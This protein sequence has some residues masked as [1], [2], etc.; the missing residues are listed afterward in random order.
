MNGRR[1]TGR[2]DATRAPGSPEAWDAR[3]EEWLT[4]AEEPGTIPDAEVGETRVVDVQPGEVR[5]VDVQLGE[6]RVADARPEA[7]SAADARHGWDAESR[8]VAGAASH[9]GAHA[10]AGAGAGVGAAVAPVSGRKPSAHVGEAAS[11]VRGDSAYGSESVGSDRV[12]SAYARGGAA[13]DRKPSARRGAVD[14]VKALMHRHR[15]LCERAVD[16]LEIAA[17]LEAH[18][19]T[20]RTATRFRHR[21]VFSLAEEMYARVPRAGDPAPQSEAPDTPGVRADWALLTLLPGA[22]CAAT[23]TGLRLTEGRPRLAVA[24]VGVFAISMG[25]RAAVRRGPLRA[26]RAWHPTTSTRAWTC[27]LLA[28]ALLGDGLLAAGIE[29]GPTGP[30]TGGSDSPWPIALASLLALTLAVVPAAWC[31]HLF[32][33]RARRRLATSRGLEE[34]ASSVRPLLLGVFGLFLCALSG[35]L[36]GSGAWLGEPPAYAAAGA[37]GALLL[38]A[39]LLT[40]HGFTHAPAVIL[41]AAGTAEA[42]ALVSVFAGRLPGC[43]L[44][45]RPV[46]NVAAAWGPG[47]VPALVCGGAALVLLIHATRTLTRAS[48]HAAHGDTP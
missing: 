37:L 34:F 44:L 30:P 29:G 7:S 47:S 1:R 31:A 38:L 48:A 24:V 27:G 35:L 18:G 13:G 9:A 39:R 32:A 15:E 42:L 22:L 14:P 8:D 20:D 17:G 25:L 26:A 23:V 43:S 36:A 40:V 21:D 45:A 19:V 5:V 3:S 41:A 10:G 11:A 33:V 12:A 46:E 16:P 6:S 2:A 4:G 28:Y